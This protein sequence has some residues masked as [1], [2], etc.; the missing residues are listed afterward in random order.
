MRGSLQ[1]PV[2][3]RLFDPDRFFK[4]QDR[5]QRFFKLDFL[6]QQL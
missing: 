5:L 1:L 3:S 6:D 4:S 2:K